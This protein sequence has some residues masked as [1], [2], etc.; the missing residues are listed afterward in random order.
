MSR[1]KTRHPVEELQPR[2]GFIVKGDVYIFEYFDAPNDK[3]L[4]LSFVIRGTLD[5]AM[6]FF[7]VLSDARWDF[8]HSTERKIAHKPKS[9]LPQPGID[10]VTEEE[11]RESPSIPENS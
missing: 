11:D 2:P 4:V 1:A 5:D 7:K 6:D 10:V 9:L 8:E 3:D